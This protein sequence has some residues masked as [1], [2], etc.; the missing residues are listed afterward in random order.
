MKRCAWVG[1]S[2]IDQDYHDQEWGSV[3]RD[4]VKL[5]EC[6]TLEGAQAGL[7]WLTILKKREGYRRCFAEFDPVKVAAFSEDDVQRLLQDTSIVRHQ[8]KIRATINNAQRILEIQEE[9]GSLS[10]YLWQFVGG[11]PR[12]N[13]WKTLTEI[14]TQTEESTAMSKALKKRGFSFVGPTTC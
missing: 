12:D 3:V 14:P 11:E 8:G 10:D 4:D 7:S 13:H 5:F 1:E 9:L 2:E 6:L